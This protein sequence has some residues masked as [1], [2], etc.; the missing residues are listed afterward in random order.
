MSGGALDSPDDP[1]QVSHGEVAGAPDLPEQF[2]SPYTIAAILGNG[3]NDQKGTFSCVGQS[4]DRGMESL[5]LWTNMPDDFDNAKVISTLFD[6]DV[7]NKVVGIT[8]FTKKH[9]K[10]FSPQYLYAMAK[11]YD[12][13]NGTGTYLE[14]GP[15]VCSS[16]GAAEESVFPSDYGLSE[17]QFRDYRR[18]SAEVLKN[19][20]DFKIVRYAYVERDQPSHRTAIYTAPG[21]GDVMGYPLGGN[22]AQPQVP[23]A[24]GQENSG[25]ANW[26][27]G[28][29]EKYCY[30]IGSW[31]SEYGVKLYLKIVDHFKF[32][33]IFAKGAPDDYS[34]AIGGVHQLS[35]AWYT[36]RLMFKGLTMFDDKFL[37]PALEKKIGMLRTIREQESGRI[38]AILGGKRYWITPGGAPQTIYEV[39]RG[40]LWPDLAPD[41]VPGL[42]RADIIKF[43]FGGIWGDPA[44]AEY[45]RAKMGQL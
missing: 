14:M 35:A 12:K 37:D 9:L 21:N 18:I 41:Q 45:I 24:P 13:F 23:P 27:F 22:M 39:G 31:G 7:D 2:F 36:S 42:P 26:E 30:A 1:R 6:V 43:Q 8:D 11:K 15:K 20:G 17:V 4:T 3:V 40:Q 19:A 33:K 34:V 44:I 28:Y 5:Q 38:F 25:H 32:G 10:N 29:D 16:D